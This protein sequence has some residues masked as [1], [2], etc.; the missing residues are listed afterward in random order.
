MQ[1]NRY[2]SDELTSDDEGNLVML[3]REHAAKNRAIIQWASR[4]DEE[5]ECELCDASND[6]ARSTELDI[7]FESL[8]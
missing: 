1:V 6:P 2:Y 4:G 3:C 8:T 5:S 7:L